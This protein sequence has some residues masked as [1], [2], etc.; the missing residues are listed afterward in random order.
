MPVIHTPDTP[1][2]KEMARHEAIH[3]KYGAPGRPYEFREFPTRMYLAVRDQSG[4][5]VLQ[6]ETANDS[7]E[8]RN[9]E[10][11]GFV[12]GGQQSALDSLAARETEHATL[13]AERNYEV[14]HGK[15]SE[16]AVEEVKFV[17]EAAGAMH[18]PE[19][20]SGP[21][22]PGRPRKIQVG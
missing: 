19:I 22:K 2:A 3:T 10:S 17:E 8:Q 18:V 14:A 9:L 16:A 7:H 15:L 1:Y 13:A 20:P 6:G 21:K 4:A 5:P 12:H 11:R